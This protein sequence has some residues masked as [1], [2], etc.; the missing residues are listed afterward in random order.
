TALPS[1]SDRHSVRVESKEGL[2]RDV[3]PEE[4]DDRCSVDRSGGANATGGG[5]AG[6]VGDDKVARA[7]ERIGL[8][9]T[10]AAA[11]RQPEAAAPSRLLRDAVGIGAREMPPG[12]QVR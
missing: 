1:G 11:I 9:E 10:R 8:V 3:S 6:H 5:G 2:D 7:G 12:R 4:L